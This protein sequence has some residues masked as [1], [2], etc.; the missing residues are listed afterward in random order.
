MARK[1]QAIEE[2]IEKK[3]SELREGARAKKDELAEIKEERRQLEVA[4]ESLKGNITSKN[5]CFRSQT[6]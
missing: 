5:G 2:I 4:L 3:V 1:R 6:S